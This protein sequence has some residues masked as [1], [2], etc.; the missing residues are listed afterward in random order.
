[1]YPRD[2][3]S[4]HRTQHMYHL[5]CHTVDWIGLDCAVFYVPANTVY[6]RRFLQVKDP[7]NSIKVP[8]ENALS[9]T[10]MPSIYFQFCR[11]IILN[12]S[13]WGGGEFEVK[14]QALEI[15]GDEN[16]KVVVYAHFR[17]S[18]RLIIADP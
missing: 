5:G 3:T 16:V 8:K 13:K 11:D 10:T 4:G 2:R 18:V 17:P 15:I 7:T 9:T 12:T 1:M 6:G 14:G